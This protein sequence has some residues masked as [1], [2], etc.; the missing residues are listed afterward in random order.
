MILHYMAIA[1]LAALAIILQTT[2]LQSVTAT[3]KVDLL[4]VMVAMLG[5]YRDP[6]HGSI[7]TCA[8]GYLQ[9]IFYY[10]PVGLFMTARVVVF[11][12]AQELKARLSPDAPLPLFSI[13]FGLGLFDRA[14]VWVLQAFFS[15]PG[16]LGGMALPQALAGTA[17]NA[18]LA[19]LLYYI[20]RKVPGFIEMPRGPRIVE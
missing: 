16:S 20:L 2:V 9:D 7:K 3:L 17:I 11:I 10:E 5:L 8:L 14:L 4:F 15:A 19:V 13:V 18:V 12:V 1:V 6:T